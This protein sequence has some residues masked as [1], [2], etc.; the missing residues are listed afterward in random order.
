MKL[1]QKIIYV[2]EQFGILEDAI[3]EKS[4][5]KYGE[6][7]GGGE[8]ISLISPEGVKS[9]IYQHFMYYE[10][11]LLARYMILVQIYSIF[12]RYAI[13]H[14]NIISE[15]EKLI[16]IDDLKGGRNFYGIKTFFT[17]V[18]NVNYLY[19]AELDKLRQVRNLI[20]HCDGYVTYSEQKSKI[21]N[22]VKK[23]S[24]LLV[25]DDDRLA[26]NKEFLKRCLRAV[27]RFFDLVE[28]K[29]IEPNGMLDLSYGHINQFLKFDRAQ[30]S[31][32]NDNTTGEEHCW[33]GEENK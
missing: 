10:G 22:T 14:S 5:E 3:C 11:P 1:S 7:F 13:S 29:A 15:K 17:K 9:V 32:L 23:D 28:P 2:Y 18:V 19:W 20:A 16:K 6:T 12:E 8:S 26:F 24:D 4:Y 27:I 30:D 21:I 25:L 33:V 31:V